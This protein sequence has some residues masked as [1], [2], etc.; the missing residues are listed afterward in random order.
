MD[1]SAHEVLR[2]GSFS[3]PKQT[4]QTA[5]EMNR[6]AEVM[7][8]YVLSQDRVFLLRLGQAA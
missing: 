7:S 2:G 1:L 4:G 6:E 8:E 3:L 5:G